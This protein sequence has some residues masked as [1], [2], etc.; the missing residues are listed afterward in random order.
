[1]KCRW[2]HVLYYLYTFIHVRRAMNYTLFELVIDANNL[3]I[4]LKKINWKVW[5][6]FTL[7]RF[8]FLCFFF[9]LFFFFGFDLFD[10]RLRVLVFR[11]HSHS[12]FFF[13]R[14]FH[15][16]MCCVFS[17]R[18]YKFKC[19]ITYVARYVS[20]CCIQIKMYR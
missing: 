8:G 4:I 15:N 5:N 2:T 7:R 18:S 11:F 6:H 17:N 1:M 20:L 9:F 10:A 14:T 3:S 12:I 16:G 19:Y 13:L